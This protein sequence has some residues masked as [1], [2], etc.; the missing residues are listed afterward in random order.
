[1]PESPEYFYLLVCFNSLQFLYLFNSTLTII[2]LCD[3]IKCVWVLIISQ[4]ITSFFFL[5]FAG[6]M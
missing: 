1:M 5:L 3:C 2:V 4:L 6:L